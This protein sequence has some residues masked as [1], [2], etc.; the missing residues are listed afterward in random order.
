MSCDVNTTQHQQDNLGFS[1]CILS[2]DSCI[3][4]FSLL[5][6]ASS[7]H[8]D[9]YIYLSAWLHH[10]KCCVCKHHT[11]IDSTTCVWIWIRKSSLNHHL[12][13]I[14]LHSSH[15]DIIFSRN[16][17]LS[18]CHKEARV[19]LKWSD[20]NSLTATRVMISSDNNYYTITSAEY[21][22]EGHTNTQTSFLVLSSLLRVFCLFTC[23]RWLIPQL[24]SFISL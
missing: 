9:Y 15:C 1:N 16:W 22:I 20:I 10:Q 21:N 11:R 12:N 4:I 19:Y 24:C 23:D 17:L 3:Y 5:I 6:V 13:H 7:T 8:L 2:G 18:C 14:T